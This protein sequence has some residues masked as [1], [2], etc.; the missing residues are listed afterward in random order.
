[1]K[2]SKLIFQLVWKLLEELRVAKDERYQ[3]VDFL[4]DNDA[5]KTSCYRLRERYFL[6]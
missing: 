6:H 2:I 5:R 3:T 1:M 4:D